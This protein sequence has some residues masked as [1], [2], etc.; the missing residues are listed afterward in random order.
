VFDP[1]F[2]DCVRFCAA[3][4]V[5]IEAA[6]LD[7][8]GPST[9]LPLG[10]GALDPDAL[11][12]LVLEEIQ[13][14]GHVVV[15]LFD[16]FRLELLDA[17]AQPRQFVLD[18]L[19]AGLQVLAV[20]EAGFDTLDFG[21]DFVFFVFE[22]FEFELELV[23][24]AV[25]HQHFG[26]VVGLAV[27]DIGFEVGDTLREVLTAL[28]QTVNILGAALDFGFDAFESVFDLLVLAALLLEFDLLGLQLVEFVVEFVAPGEFLVAERTQT[29]ECRFD[30]GGA[31]LTPT[32]PAGDLFAFGEEV[33]GGPP[34]VV[35]GLEG[36]E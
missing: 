25:D 13:N 8:V 24:L 29:L 7:A 14:R 4:D 10:F 34:V 15:E 20:F 26:V 16:G 1:I 18:F 5:E 36:S 35:C 12:V 2:V 31:D 33:V 3:D 19:A 27:F 6:L 30:V 11:Q 22:T 23:G 9:G 17:G 21:F 28:F 32:G